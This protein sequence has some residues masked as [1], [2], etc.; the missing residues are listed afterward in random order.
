MSEPSVQDV[1]SRADV[2]LLLRVVRA[3]FLNMDPTESNAIVL[4]I[5]GLRWLAEEESVVSR[6]SLEAEEAYWVDHS[7]VPM[8]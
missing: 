1:V 8:Q 3:R 4:A 7:I 5:E 2:A 6:A